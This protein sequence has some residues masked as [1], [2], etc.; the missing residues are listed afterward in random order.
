VLAYLIRQWAIMVDGNYPVTAILKFVAHSLIM[1]DG[2]ASV[3]M[4]A[5]DEHAHA[6]NRQALIIEAR[7]DVHIGRGLIRVL[8][9]LM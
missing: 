5:I 1:F 9:R 3:M 4:K 8:G 7:L 6:G 2:G